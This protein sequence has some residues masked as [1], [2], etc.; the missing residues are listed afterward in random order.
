MG[1]TA[2]EVVNS[3]QFAIM[4]PSQIV[5]HETITKVVS[6]TSTLLVV[7]WG[8]D[9]TSDSRNWTRFFLGTNGYFLLQLPMG[10]EHQSNGS[11]VI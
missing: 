10:W 1:A 8:V 2:A 5:F 3:G 7:Q 4:P 6:T 9:L 11:R